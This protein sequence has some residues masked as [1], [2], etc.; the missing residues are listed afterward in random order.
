MLPPSFAVLEERLRKRSR[1]PEAA[2]AR[3][4]AT[5]RQEVSAVDAYDY[6]VVNDVMER[7]VGEL[8]GIVMAER[9]KLA[10]RRAAIQPIIDSF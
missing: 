5:A 1:D 4:L 6:V 2:M 8:A 3:R 10:R 7:C 9:A